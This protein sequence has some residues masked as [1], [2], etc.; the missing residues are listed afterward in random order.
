MSA[1]EYSMA[2]SNIILK[3]LVKELSTISGVVAFSIF[4]LPENK[5]KRINFLK[6]FIKRKKAY[7]LP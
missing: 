5:N 4:Q 6:I 1:A 3:D 2:G 7:T